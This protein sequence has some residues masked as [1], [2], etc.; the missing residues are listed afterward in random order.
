MVLVFKNSF[1]TLVCSS[2]LDWSHSSGAVL[3][4]YGMLANVATVGSTNR[5]M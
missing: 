2:G 4:V 5:L 1:S 3:P